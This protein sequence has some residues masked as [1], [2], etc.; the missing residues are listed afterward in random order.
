MFVLYHLVKHTAIIVQVNQ[1]ERRHTFILD[2]LFI[3]YIL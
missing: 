2:Y 1:V 3:M